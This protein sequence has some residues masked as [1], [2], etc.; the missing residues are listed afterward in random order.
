MILA[1]SCNE[2]LDMPHEETV[3]HN[4]VINMVVP[5]GSLID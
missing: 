4:D 1:R 5:Y 3:F 2:T